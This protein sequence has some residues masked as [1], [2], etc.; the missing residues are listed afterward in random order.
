MTAA[1]LRTFFNPSNSQDYY[2]D[3]LICIMEGSA[4]SEKYPM[5]IN[6]F[7]EM[8]SFYEI[9]GCTY[10]IDAFAGYRSDVS[11]IDQVVEEANKLCQTIDQRTNV[12][13]NQGQVRKLREIMFSDDKNA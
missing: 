9:T 7:T 13:E 11:V 4:L 8:K 2:L 12:Y 6:L 5:L 1:I 10:A 3:D